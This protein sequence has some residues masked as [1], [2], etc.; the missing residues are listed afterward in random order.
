MTPWAFTAYSFTCSM[1]ELLQGLGECVRHFLVSQG[2]TF[3]GSVNSPFLQF[4]LVIRI[5]CSLVGAGGEEGIRFVDKN[6]FVHSSFFTWISLLPIFSLGLLRSFV[7]FE[8]WDSFYH[9]HECSPSFR[10]IT[11]SSCITPIQ[12]EEVSIEEIL[13]ILWILLRGRLFLRRSPVFNNHLQLKLHIYCLSWGFITL[14]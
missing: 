14:H 8:I 3:N 12:Y 6:S 11:L 5:E 7:A 9:R 10:L 13:K 2:W 1:H 4:L